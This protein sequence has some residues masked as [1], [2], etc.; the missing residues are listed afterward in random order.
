MFKIKKKK[1]LKYLPT[2]ITIHLPL[3]SRILEPLKINGS[4]SFSTSPFLI[5]SDSPVAL[6]SS[7][8]R[9][10]PHKNIPSTGTISPGSRNYK[11]NALSQI[12]LI[13]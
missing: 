8:T 5:G 7:Q 12:L 11:E 13:K 2:A 3:P 1:I 10:C 9:L 4:K 6:D